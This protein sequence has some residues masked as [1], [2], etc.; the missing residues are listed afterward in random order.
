MNF[1][2]CD[3]ECSLQ[4][5]WGRTGLT[6]AGIQVEKNLRSYI[7]IQISLALRARIYVEWDNNLLKR[8]TWGLKYS[9]FQVNIHKFILVSVR[10]S[11][12]CFSEIRILFLLGINRA[13]NK[14]LNIKKNSSGTRSHYLINKICILFIPQNSPQNDPFSGQYIK[15]FQLVVCIRINCL[16]CIASYFMVT[17]IA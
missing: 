4:R 10:V 8:I 6:R 5:L 16:V 14:V 1:G 13:Y 11:L 12:F 3:F 2:Q 7:K 17:K 15:Y 9:V